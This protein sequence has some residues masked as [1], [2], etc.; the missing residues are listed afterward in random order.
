MSEYKQKLY[1]LTRM[2]YE[3]QAKWFL[4]GFWKEGAEQESENIWKCTHK[5]IELDDRKKEGNELDEFRAHKFLESL[6]ET[7]TVI[8]LREKLKK[9][10]LDVNGKMGLLEYLTFK[11]NK[12]IKEVVEA[13]QG[14]NQEEIEE[15][16]QKLQAVQDALNEVQ[17]QL[18]Q[19][20]K[21]LAEQKTAL[22][23]SKRTADEAKRTANEAKRT[24]DA[25]KKAEDDVR[26]AEEEQ[27]AAV[28]ELKKQEDNYHNQI[29]LL[30]SKSKD[31]NATT[32]A[33]HK[34][35]A[36]LAQ[37][38]QEDPLPLRKAKI[39]QEAT[40][41]KVE[42]ERK[43]AE[44]ATSVAEKAALAAKEAADNAE[45]AAVEAE[46]K[47]RA[48][49]EQKKKVE[50]AKEEAESRVKEALDYLESVKKKGGIAYGSIWWME[51]ELKEAQ[52][53]LP[54]RKQQQI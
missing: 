53:Y 45:A 5:F 20:E 24:L 52:K 42:K 44:A 8:Q 6:G 51:R 2:K 22:E 10:D 9:I 23:E 28:E 13:P 7:L 31:P 43:I 25:Q 14:D 21:A 54:K 1:E 32:V 35:A 15:A 37:L 41:R 17:N 19:Q 50:A 12:T 30:E 3:D 39:S 33:K 26:K 27:R 29:N 40:L 49:E 38:K 16:Q 46:E 4:N 36:E 18:E 11:Y 47:T 34:A 48:L